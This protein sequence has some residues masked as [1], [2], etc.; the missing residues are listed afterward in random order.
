MTRFQRNNVWNNAPIKKFKGAT[1][2][3][4]GV[5]CLR[6]KNVTKMVSYDIFCERLGIY[7]M[8]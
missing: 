4:D 3:I 5:I 6:S 8:T 7:I 1:P 2:K